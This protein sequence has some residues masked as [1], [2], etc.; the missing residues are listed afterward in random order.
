MT[1]YHISNDANLNRSLFAISL[2]PASSETMQAQLLRTLKGLLGEAIHAGRRLPAS[3]T[4]A[5]ELSVSRTTVQAVYE[6]LLSE[7]YLTAHQG[8]G[9]F[10]AQDLP[11]LRT[12]ET[13]H[14]FTTPEPSQWRPF[15]IGLPDHGLLP[16]RIWARHLERAWARP[17]EALLGRSDPLGWY[18]L[19]A[20]IADHLLAWRQLACDP[21]QIVITTGAWDSLELVFRGV[22]DDHSTVM[23]EDPSW[24]RLH[25]AARAH[26]IAAIASRIDNKGFNPDQ[27]ENHARA[28][29]VTPSRHYP[30][31][32]SMPLSR[33]IALI[34]WAR[35][36][37]GVI[38]EDD[39]DS[40]FRYRG[41]P[42]PALA[43]LD[44]LRNTIY[45]GSFSK[46]ISP[47]LRI[48]YAVVPRQHLGQ[49]NAYLNCTGTR[50][51]LIPQ[52]AL[53]SFL[54]SGEFAVHLRRMRRTYAKRQRHLLDE[55]APLSDLLKLLPDPSGMHLCLPLKPGAPQS[56]TE[57][58]SAARK[59]DLSVGALSSHCVLAD[60]P[61]ALLLGYAAFPE[62]SLS[63]AANVLIDIMASARHRA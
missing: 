8:R 21:E 51:S 38:I 7:G 16:H 52:P 29:I 23:I 49:V 55:L 36:T 45:L 9:T 57:I 62:S 11:H 59:S 1:N 53:A 31:G 19:R 39:Y 50:A 41:Q 56:D 40:E 43:G 14:S 46:L 13:S 28:V 37:G 44:G 26:S 47:A 25:D 42:L 2:D 27:I 17:D 4:L 12:P 30:T 5:A 34:D 35:S 22:L 18:P 63:N 32:T 3:R 58:A 60:R 48:G 10:V 33:R 24:S 54:N 61:Q 6:Q 15:E 20:A